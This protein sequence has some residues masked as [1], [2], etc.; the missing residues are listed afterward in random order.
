MHSLSF[1]PS[2]LLSY[3]LLISSLLCVLL[4]QFPPS[5]TWYGTNIT[6]SDSCICSMI[7]LLLDDV[8][9]TDSMAVGT[10]EQSCTNSCR[11]QHFRS[12]RDRCRTCCT[13]VKNS[14]NW[15]WGFGTKVI[16]QVGS[17]STGIIHHALQTLRQV[18]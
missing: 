5:V 4:A 18:Y 1:L 9:M 15:I 10:G 11:G 16:L 17:L 3:P 13:H 14:I 6:C 7:S 8:A 12:R 2:H